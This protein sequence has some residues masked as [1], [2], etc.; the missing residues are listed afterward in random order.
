MGWQLKK[1]KQTIKTVCHALALFKLEYVV[2]S[3][4]SCG[5]DDSLNHKIKLLL[6]FETSVLLDKRKEDFV[7][8]LNKH[9]YIKE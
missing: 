9:N 5:P 7:L 6:P 1:F 3:D 4:T 2:P 8:I